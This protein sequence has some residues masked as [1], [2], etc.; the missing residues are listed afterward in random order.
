MAYAQKPFTEGT[1]IYKVKLLST[2]NNEIDG[3]YTF[4]FKGDNIRKELKLN[5][6]YEDVVLINANAG[7]IYSLQ[8]QAG[9]KYAIEL[10]MADVRKAQERYAGFIMLN[11]ESS[12]KNIAGCNSIYKGN[13][14]YKDGSSA[15]VYYTKEWFPSQS[16]TFDRFP[17]ARFFPMTFTYKDENNITMRFEATQ[18]LPGPV[19]SGIFRIPADYK[20]IS[21]TEYKQLNK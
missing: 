13:I 4:T 9:K 12:R 1:I 15:E 6:G 14:S 11:E 10:N 2:D 7:T 21:N 18:F 19:E 20:M 5:N 17:S 8:S 16:F 3:T